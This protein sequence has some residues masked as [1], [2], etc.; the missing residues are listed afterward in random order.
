VTVKFSPHHLNLKSRD[1]WVTAT[2][3]LPP[4]YD[5]SQVDRAGIGLVVG[6]SDPVMAAQPEPQH[7][8]FT[9]IWRKIQCRMNF[10]AVK[11]DRQEVIRA[12]GSASG[13]IVLTVDGEVLHNGGWLEFSGS[14]AIQTFEKSNRWGFLKKGWRKRK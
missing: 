2:I 8:L 7:G 6:K 3:Q 10:V 1:K 12:I 11:F 9:K 4:E 13:T 14:G 5:P